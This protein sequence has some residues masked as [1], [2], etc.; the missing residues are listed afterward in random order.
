[1]RQLYPLEMMAIR[2]A[3]SRERDAL[4]RLSEWITDPVDALA[5]RE[6]VARID[7]LIDLLK[8]G[9]RVSVGT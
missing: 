1:M 5:Y 6:R 4:R 7:G 8:P 3:L 9:T 2:M